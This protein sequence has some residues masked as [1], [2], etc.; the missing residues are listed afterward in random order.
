MAAFVIR[1]L[2]VTIVTVL[3][4]MILLF[5]IIQMIPGDPATVL[6]GPRATPEMMERIRS[7]MGLDRAVHIQLGRFLAN[8]LRGDLGTDVL[9]Y[10][11]VRTLIFQVLPYTFFLAISSIFLASAI[12]IPLGAYSAAYRNSI[13]DRITGVISIA[14]ITTPAFLAGL[15]FLLFFSLHLGWFPAMGGGETG[16]ILSHLYY[17]ILPAFSLALGWIGYI[18]RI[19]RS[20]VLEELTEDYVRTARAKGLSERVI[21][22]KHVLRSSLIPVISVIGVGF[23]N[24]LGGALLIEII[25]HRPG[26]GYLIYNA[27]SSRNYPIV[28]GGLIVAIFLYSLANLFA[29]LSY[30]FIDPRVR[31]E[32]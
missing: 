28:Q 29:D 26:L 11:P 15:L 12:G 8:V 17:L 30:G 7:S 10:M 4:A 9:N 23:G 14:F 2:M 24:L 5:F 20:S 27:I 31:G 32:R 19:M 18:A 6:L 25:F 3:G 16:N 1:R 13:L 22:Y 21:L